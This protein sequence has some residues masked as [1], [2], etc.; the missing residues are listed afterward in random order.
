M[1]TCEASKDS[2]KLEKSHVHKGQ[3]GKP[4]SDVLNVKFLIGKNG[5]SILCGDHPAC[6]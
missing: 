3:T 6:Y 4:K 2:E 5:H 1:Q